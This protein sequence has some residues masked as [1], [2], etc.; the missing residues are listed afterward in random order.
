MLNSKVVTFFAQCTFKDLGGIYDFYPRQIQEIPLIIPSSDSPE[1]KK[2]CESS[3]RL[4]ENLTD[5]QRKVLM[6]TLNDDIFKLYNLS[7]D[8]IMLIE[9]IFE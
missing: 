3:M 6:T 7:Q 1:F 8:D 4:H 9:S 5:Q 2:I